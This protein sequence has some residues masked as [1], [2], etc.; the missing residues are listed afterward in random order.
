MT[1]QTVSMV[2]RITRLVAGNGFLAHLEVCGQ[3]VL[4]ANEDF[5][6]PFILSAVQPSGVIGR[7]KTLQE[8]IRSFE[9]S[10]DAGIDPERGQLRDFGT[11]AAWWQTDFAKVSPRN[12][13]MWMAGA[14][15]DPERTETPDPHVPSILITPLLVEGLLPS[16]NSTATYGAV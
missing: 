8:A 13:E 6:N 3:A 9:I 2:Y 14:N 15:L 12:L 7:G 1:Q 5:L 16:H 11:F 10:F 4:M